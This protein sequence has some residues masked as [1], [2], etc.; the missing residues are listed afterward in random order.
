M[1]GDGQNQPEGELGAS[2]SDY[3]PNRGEFNPRIGASFGQFAM[4][5]SRESVW[6]NGSGLD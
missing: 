3:S 6:S 4:A 2:P 5:Q 1:T